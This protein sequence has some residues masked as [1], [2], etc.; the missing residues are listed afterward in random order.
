MT[1]PNTLD[2]AAI[3]N[4]T[5]N[6]S[7]GVS[8][9]P[10]FNELLIIGPTQ[11]IPLATRVYEFTSLTDILAYGYQITDPEYIAAQLYFGQTPKPYKVMLGLKYLTSPAETVIQAVTACRAKSHNWYMCMVTDATASDHLACAAYLEA[12]SPLSVYVYT[13]ADANVLLASPSPNDIATTLKGLLYKRTIGQYSTKE[14]RAIAAIM[15]YAC[16]QNSGLANSAFTLK[17][18]N[19]VGVTA[20]PMDANTLAIIEGKNLNLYLNYNDFYNFFEQGV[21]ANGWFF[22]R[23]VNLDML[24]TNIQLNVANL[25]YSS[26]K[27][28]QTEAG[29]HMIMSAVQQACETAFTVGYIGPGVWNGPTVLNLMDG[30]ALPRGYSIQAQP[31]TEQSSADR[32]LRKSPPIYVCITEAG[33]I[34]SLVVQVNVSS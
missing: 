14:A 30:D 7:P 32:A 27:V 34:H 18:K 24:G 17:F 25:L 15:G 12:A 6:V 13:T 22:D 9:I 2:L 26:A 11:K 20:E 21:M 33:A 29:V 23:V 28:P 4:Y 1:Y 3:V 8:P 19:E 16:G 10:G 31:L 5:V